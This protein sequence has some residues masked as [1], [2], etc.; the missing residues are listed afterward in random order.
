[1]PGEDSLADQMGLGKTLTIIA[2]LAST[3]DAADVWSQTSEQAADDGIELCSVRTTLAAAGTPNSLT[4]LGKN[5]W[6]LILSANLSTGTQ[7]SWDQ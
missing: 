7:I 4:E 3:I 6:K 2:L 5:N 1:M